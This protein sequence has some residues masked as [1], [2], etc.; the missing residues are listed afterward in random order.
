MA[1]AAP[2]SF[3]FDYLPGNIVGKADVRDVLHYL[4]KKDRPYLV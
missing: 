2:Y 1:K 4:N 3:V